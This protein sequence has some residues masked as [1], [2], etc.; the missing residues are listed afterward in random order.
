MQ[1]I[2]SEGINTLLKLPRKLKSS[3][4]FLGDIFISIFTV[5]ISF[6]LRLGNFDY[7]NRN[8]LGALLISIIISIPI[9]IWSGFYKA[10]FRYSNLRI[11]LPISKGIAIY[12]IFYSFIIS[13]IGIDGVP[14]TIGLIQPFLY[15]FCI[16][17][18]RLVIAHFLRTK[19]INKKNKSL[20][21]R[22]FIYGAGDA[23]SKLFANLENDFEIK[24]IGFLD[25]DETKQG[26]SLNGKFIYRTNN[27]KELL[28][29]KNIS[30]VLLAI[31]SAKRYRRIEII[32]K[33]I[34]CKVS[35]RTL[36]S[37]KSINSRKIS[38]FNL[39]DLDIDDLLS[40]EIIEPYKELLIKDTAHKVVLVTGAGGS[41]GGELCKQIINLNPEKL[42]IL[43]NSEFAL[44]KILNSLEV[45]ISKNKIKAS[46]F[47]I[48]A[49]VQD[50]KK[51]SEIISS[52]KPH[53]VYHAAA[54]K[55]VPLVER[56]LLEGLKNNVFGTLSTASIAI[57]QK[58][59]NFVL[60]S[61]DKAVRPTNAMGASKRLA[62]MCLQALF[63]NQKGNI[64]TKLSMVRFGNVMDS[65]GSVIPKF[66][67]QIKKRESL[68]LTHPEITRYFM[69][70]REAAQLVIQAGALAQ[71]G[72]VFILDMG[73][74]IKI[75]D[76][77]E[78]MIKL[79][80]L[81]LKSKNNP[82]G[83]LEIKITGLR[84]GEKLFEEPLMG[85]YASRTIHPKIFKAQDPFI[86]WMELT[87]EINNLEEL[88]NLNK[89][90]DV[91]NIL[92]R[93]VTGYVP[94]KEIYNYSFKDN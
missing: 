39:L 5:C 64:T 38:D 43:D 16:C 7:L 87:Q 83:D 23:G 60:I 1:V 29:E 77:A 56:N 30:H 53:T 54:Y 12:S 42:L 78:R 82:S 75:I 37:L 32:R 18:F 46:I 71:G 51:I 13:L 19:F 9:F 88:I 59:S 31:P 94:S 63:A 85:D 67:E 4:V 34:D 81:T 48:L 70:I 66:R 3:V 93:L 21:Q 27:L 14:R 33:L 11:L 50:V 49:S 58:V 20:M 90:E 52:W 22:A 57:E 40:R 91:L 35:I 65:S 2:Y 28:V 61:T 6:Y 15:F 45:L 74:P 8:L 17:L 92:K 80:G 55:H 44:Y 79:S 26:R 73:E 86:D 41:I 36:P 62:E 69:T 10:I 84:P 89:I 25:D 68:T 24:I 76:L 72:D 47:P